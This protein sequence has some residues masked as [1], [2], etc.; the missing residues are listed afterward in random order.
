MLKERWA[1]LTLG[2][3]QRLPIWEIC[4]GVGKAHRLISPALLQTK[5]L[6]FQITTNHHF[7]MNYERIFGIHLHVISR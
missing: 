7:E 3:I 6:T 2:G 5:L 1:L 4:W